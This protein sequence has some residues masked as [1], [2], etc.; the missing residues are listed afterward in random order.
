MTKNDLFLLLDSWDN[1]N[2][3]KSNAEGYTGYIPLL[4][5]IALNGTNRL[6]WRAA[7]IAE[8]INE[9]HPG[10]LQP[11]INSIT[12]SLNGMNHIGKKRQFLKLLCLY[13]ISTEHYPFLLDYCLQIL[14]TMSEPPANKAYSMQILYNI[15]EYEPGLKEE[16][17]DIMEY[18]LETE[19]S[20]GT[21]A[22]ARIIAGK[23]S[24]EVRRKG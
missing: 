11:W 2:W 21:L 24:K 19:Q 23:L 10:I 5:D 14:D 15:S 3:V 20:A 8:K 9:K 16:L 13:P 7:W 4:M 22:K 6:S 12:N 18:L 1:L 17:L